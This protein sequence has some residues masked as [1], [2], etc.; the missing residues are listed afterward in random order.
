MRFDISKKPPID[1]TDPIKDAFPRD[2]MRQLWK[3]V[4]VEVMA[5]VNSVEKCQNQDFF[6]ALELPTSIRKSARE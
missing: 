2:W 5:S 3:S 1:N 6:R 4:V